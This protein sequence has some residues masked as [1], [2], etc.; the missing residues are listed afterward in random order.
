MS[1]QITELKLMEKL[2]KKL[3]K[4]TDNHTKQRIAL[5]KEMKN[6][7]K[8]IGNLSELPVSIK[9][10]NYGIN[11]L[12]DHMKFMSKLFDGYKEGLCDYENR[13]I[14]QEKLMSMSLKAHL[15]KGLIDEPDVQAIIDDLQSLIKKPE[16]KRR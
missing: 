6:L 15:E 11:D 10:L 7:S 14:A 13:L 3:Q 9:K 2:I 4:V 8:E 5:T 12:R 1:G 16:E